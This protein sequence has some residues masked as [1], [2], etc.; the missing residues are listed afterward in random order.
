LVLCIR[1]SLLIDLSVAK[2]TAALAMAVSTASRRRQLVV[3]TMLLAKAVDV[4]HLHDADC[5]RPPPLVALLEVRLPQLLGPVR[6]LD[7]GVLLHERA[8]RLERRE[9]LLHRHRGHAVPHFLHARSHVRMQL[10]LRG[11]GFMDAMN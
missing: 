6:E 3:M 5:G 2:E 7:P 11:C 4:I 10:A 8:V 9:L 1:T